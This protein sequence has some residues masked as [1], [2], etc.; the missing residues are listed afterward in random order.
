MSVWT[1]VVAPEDWRT[2]RSL[3]LR[4]LLQNPDAFGSTHDREAEFDEDTWRSRL[5]G[6][7]GPA[8]IAHVDET[9][10]GLGAGWIYEPGRLMVVA[11]WTEPA[12]RGH[13]VGRKVLDHVVAWARQ[14]NLRPNLW[15]ADTNPEAR[16]LYERYGF[17]ADGE[18]TPL[19]DGSDLTM[20]RLVLPG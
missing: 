8:V 10:V 15:V 20:S 5:D 16:R 19:R 6:T 4:A 1:Q 9:P 14:R 11:M 13:G 12:W 3:R 18:T 2:W 7:G 17:R